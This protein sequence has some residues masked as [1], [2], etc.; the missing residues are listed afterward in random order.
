[1][2]GNM[3]KEGFKNHNRLLNQREIERI[4]DAYPDDRFANLLE[5]QDAKTF[6]AVFD[7]LRP[8]FVGEH[9]METMLFKADF[10]RIYESFY[11]I[12]T[13]HEVK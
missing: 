11:G 8:E 4:R 7:K 2:G 3:E 10:E 13:V 6:E 12:N 1:M 5:A 9:G